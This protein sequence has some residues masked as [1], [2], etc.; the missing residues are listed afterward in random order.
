MLTTLN[1]SRGSDM[2]HDSLTARQ[3]SRNDISN[4]AHIFETSFRYYLEHNSPL[5]E[6][7]R[8]ALKT[9]VG[10]GF[11]AILVDESLASIYWSRLETVVKHK[12]FTGSI[13]TALALATAEIVFEATYIFSILGYPSYYDDFISALKNI[14]HHISIDLAGK[15]E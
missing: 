7:Y 12:N 10:L 14:L 5:Q 15:R 3:F 1:L 2:A 13:I 6:N 8:R 9:V 4:L 11:T